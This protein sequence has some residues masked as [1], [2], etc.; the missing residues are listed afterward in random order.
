ME[1]MWI[2]KIYYYFERIV[3]NITDLTDEEGNVFY[4]N[5]SFQSNL[6]S[7]SVIHFNHLK[8]LVTIKLATSYF[9]YL[10]PVLLWDPIQRKRQFLGTK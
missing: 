1:N 6:A 9:H 5:C 2:I 7:D 4:L 3:A 8:R 10:G